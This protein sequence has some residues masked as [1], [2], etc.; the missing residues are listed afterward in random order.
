MPSNLTEEDFRQLAEWTDGF[1][2]A[3]INILCRDAAMAPVNKIQQAEWFVEY[4]G[5]LWPCNEG[6]P[7]AVRTRVLDMT[8]AQ[9]EMLKPLDLCMEDFGIALGKT[10]PSVSPNDLQRFEKWT[11]EFGQ[12]GN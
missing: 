7:G 11:A 4:E 5:R 2:G 12:E 9:L 8:P 10:R 6:Q 1:S 3:D